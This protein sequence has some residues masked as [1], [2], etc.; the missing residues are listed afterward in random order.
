LHGDE[1]D[2]YIRELKMK[3]GKPVIKAFSVG[4]SPVETDS[5]AEYLLFDAPGR[6]SRG[7]SGTTFDWS[8]I[9]AVRR[10]YFLAGG[11]DITNIASAIEKLSPYGVDVSSGA[12]TDGKKDLGK[13]SDII[14]TVKEKMIP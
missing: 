3:T 13:M 5:R 6:S 4:D 1:G 14:K 9:E 7:G 12:E 10:P 11:L 2:E 8:R